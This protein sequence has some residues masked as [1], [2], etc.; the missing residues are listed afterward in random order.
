MA[1]ATRRDRRKKRTPAKEN[2]CAISSDAVTN[3]LCLELLSD[4]SFIVNEANVITWSNDAFVRAFD[5]KEDPAEGK[6]TCE[7]VCGTHLCGTKH[8]PVGKAGRLQKA[9]DAEVIR[10][11]G[12]G[13]PTY[14]RSIAT[15][16]DGD[17]PMTLVSMREITEKKQMEGRLHQ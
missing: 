13:H 4:P 3:G 9:V 11:N 16:I 17:E 10:S 15:P 5:L 14:Y 12:N 7:E 8:C 2:D 6:L 1:T